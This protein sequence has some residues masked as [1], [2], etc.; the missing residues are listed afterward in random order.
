MVFKSL[1]PASMVSGC[2]SFILKA[3]SS[4]FTGITLLKLFNATI[5]VVLALNKSKITQNIFIVVMCLIVVFSP[6]GVGI[7]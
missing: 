7:Y 4:L 5:I 3:C 6:C 1:S 2:S